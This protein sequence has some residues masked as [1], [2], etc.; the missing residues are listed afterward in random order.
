M[1]KPGIIIPLIVLV[2][3]A[4]LSLATNGTWTSWLGGHAEQETDDAYVRAGM[5]PLSTRISG[6]VW[7][8]DVEDFQKVKAAKYWSRS[9][10]TNIARS[11]GRQRRN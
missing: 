11:S 2:F 4:L 5:T 7:K 6:T 9:T 3:A 1:S 8:M 10:T